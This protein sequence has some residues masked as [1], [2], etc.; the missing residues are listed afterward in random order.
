MIISTNKIAK[1]LI[2]YKSA[3]YKLTDVPMLVDQQ[4]SLHTVPKE[5]KHNEHLYHG[6]KVY[7]ASAEQSFVQLHKEGKIG[8]GKYCAITP[9][10]RHHDI[11]LVN[12][13][14]FLKIELIEIGTENYSTVLTD[15]MQTMSLLVD[16]ETWAKSDVHTEEKDGIVDFIVG[17]LEVGSYG[18]RKMIDG[19]DYCF[20]TGL[21]EPRFSHSIYP[22]LY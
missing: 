17:G 16:G 11:G 4:A 14:I 19:T 7:V 18:N 8:D 6:V 22:N 2:Y 20:G 3:G 9:C 15:A 1:A 10:Y 21:A 12:Y 5:R 13:E